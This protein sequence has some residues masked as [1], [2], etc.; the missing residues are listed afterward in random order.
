[1][2]VPHLKEIGHTQALQ[3]NNVF[4]NKFNPFVFTN[5]CTD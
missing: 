1:M 4:N 3:E 2:I 5:E